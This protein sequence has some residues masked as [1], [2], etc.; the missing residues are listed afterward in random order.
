M[1][2]L[3][4]DIVNWVD[5]IVGLLLAI[6]L[7]A[8]VPYF[9][10]LAVRIAINKF[11][12][13][14][15]TLH[16]DRFKRHFWKWLPIFFVILVAWGIGGL[17]SDLSMFKDISE[18]WLMY[19]LIG[20]GA[21]LLLAGVIPG[22]ILLKKYFKTGQN[23][24]WWWGIGLAFVLPGIII[25]LTIKV[26]E[27]YFE[28]SPSCYLPP[29]PS[30]NFKHLLPLAFTDYRNDLIKK[31]RHKLPSNVWEKISNPEDRS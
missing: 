11:K 12:K 26:V 8:G 25:Y 23:K 7:L 3:V 16:S 2:D 31:Y 17:L 18:Q 9:S 15:R 28:P 5:L 24:Y 20:A 29:P 4:L 14:D 19:Y 27:G 22:A 13:Q 10:Y 21:L 6:L 30:L 1:K